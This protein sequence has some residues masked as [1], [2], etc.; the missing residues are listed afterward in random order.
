MDTSVRY[1]LNRL[2]SDIQLSSASFINLN[3]KFS[4]ESI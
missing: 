3:G 4:S 2:G 1:R